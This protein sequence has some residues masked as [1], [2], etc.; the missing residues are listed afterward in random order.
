MKLQIKTFLLIIFFTFPLYAQWSSEWT[1]ASTSSDNAA[2]WVRFD[3]NGDSWDYRF[4]IIDYNSIQI[5]SGPNSNSVEYTYSFSAEEQTA[6]NQIYSL[7]ADLTGDNITEFYV[8]AYHDDT[9]NP[10]QSFKIVDITSGEIV[11]QKSS[12]GLF[13]T[14]PVIW[15]IDNDGILE[16]TFAVY[17]YPNFVNY[18]YQV[19]NTGVVSNVANQEMPAQFRLEQNY[20]N[21][22]NP[23]TTIEYS[24]SKPQNIKIDIYDVK[25]ALVNTL[26]DEFKTSGQHQTHWNGNNK[27]GRRVSS[28]VYFYQ[29]SSA[30]KIESKKMIMLK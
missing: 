11:F 29:I 4:Y 25:G 6:G 17:D 14:Y 21:P 8:L 26:V 27:N 16:C 20:P 22:F 13:F 3:A 12:S 15:D 7:A 28:G 10:R 2:G 1:S 5:M 24:V 9:E 30:D 18:Y 23:S 19:Y